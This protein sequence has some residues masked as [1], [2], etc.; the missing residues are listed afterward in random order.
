MSWQDIYKSRLGTVTEAVNLLKDGD[1][2]V[3]AHCI[4]EAS[5][6]QT[7]MCRQAKEQDKFHNVEVSH[8]VYMGK[9]E[10][11]QPDM[12][13]HFFHNSLFIGGA[14]RTAIKEHRADIVPCHFSEIPA[15]F[16][17]GDFPV[18]VFA[19]KCTPPNKA[20]YVNIGL[21]CDY[22]VAARMMAKTVI[23]EVDENVPATFGDTWVHVSEID[24]FYVNNSPL[25]ELQPPKIGDMEMKI[26]KNVADLIH[27]GDCLQLGIGALPDAILTFLG[28]KK[29]LG[30]HTEM[31]SDGVLPLIENGVINCKK[32][33]ID[34]GKIV[35]TFIMGTQKIYDF[36]DQNP[37]VVFK[38]VDV[39]NNPYEIAK[40]DNVVSIN[41][42]IEIDLMGQACSEAIGE[43]QISGI[44]GQMDFI[45]GANMSK[46]GRAILAISSTTPKGQSKIVPF[47]THGATVTA[48]RADVNYV[49][50]EYGVAKLKGKNLRQR[51]RQLIN[52]AHPDVRPDLIKEYERR[53]SEKF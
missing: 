17:S 2:L 28:D 36:V 4:M 20:G 23:A 30:I 16:R 10:Y 25:I 32:K 19:F 48:H 1:R 18:D 5:E 14:A 8:M 7:E 50:T 22:G 3:L 12:K 13:G 39:T 46:G 45:K 38:P 15:L 35:T 26:G 33:Q 40:N 44:G 53:F 24:A 11:L 52:I 37:F 43:R 41:S 21:S 42:C 9:G 27:D 47:L 51:A 49:V 34:V 29:D 6:F 31:I